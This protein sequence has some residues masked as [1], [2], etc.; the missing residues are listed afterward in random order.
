MT[1]SRPEKHP[2]VTT[3]LSLAIA[4]VSLLM[5]LGSF[6]FS[7]KVEQSRSEN[8][9]VSIHPIWHGYES[10]IKPSFAGWFTLRQPI[11]RYF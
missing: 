10:G 8:V 6:Y 3:W 9:E 4:L 2:L 5:S 11:G 7:M 1:T